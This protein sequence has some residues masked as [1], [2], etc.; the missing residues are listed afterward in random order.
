MNPE[1]I[2]PDVIS[3]IADHIESVVQLEVLLL[4]QAT[5]ATE[6]AA[7]ELAKKLAID[8]VWAEGQLTNL[9][10]RGLLTSTPPPNSL[11]RYAPKAPELDRAARGLAQAYADRRVSV[12]SAIF[13]KP[14]EQIRSFADA[15]KLRRDNPGG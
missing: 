4:L 7:V 12:I 10:N 8:P 3:F 14:S 1:G 9:C 13:S 15:F 11:Y 6:Y 2:P 5:P